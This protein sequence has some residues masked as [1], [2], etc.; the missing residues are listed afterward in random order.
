MDRL[1]YL[2]S[3]PLVLVFVFSLVRAVVLIFIVLPISYFVLKD[4]KVVDGII[5]LFTKSFRPSK[6]YWLLLFMFI[7]VFYFIYFWQRPLYGLIPS[8]F[9]SGVVVVNTQWVGFR[10]RKKRK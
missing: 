2:L 5:E 4:Q 3:L 9:L 7:S 10:K 1:V 6:I 8:S